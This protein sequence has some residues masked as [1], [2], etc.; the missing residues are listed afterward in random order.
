MS[1]G[2]LFALLLLIALAVSM[3]LLKPQVP[4]RIVFAGFAAGV[5]LLP[6]FETHYSRLSV[7]S[8]I[9]MLVGFLHE[10]AAWLTEGRPRPPWLE[11]LLDPAGRLGL[12][13]QG[14]RGL[15]IGLGALVLTVG[16]YLLATQPAP[17]RPAWMGPK[18]V[19]PHPQPDNRG[20]FRRLVEN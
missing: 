17:E 15:T 18:P 13:K 2:G 8:F 5:F 11:W 16:L 14:R 7:F 9:L 20:W 10:L 3:A 12:G 19:F 4:G 1:V 6:M